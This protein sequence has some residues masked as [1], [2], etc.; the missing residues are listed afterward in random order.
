MKNNLQS[1]SNEKLR[2]LI[3][4]AGSYQV[5]SIK[6][7]KSYG[8]EVF[9]ADQCENALALSFSDGYKIIDI[10]DRNAILEY[11]AELNIDGIIPMNDFGTRSAFF[12]AQKL[13]LP[14]PS[15][16]T[17]ICGND[18]GLMRDVWKHE[19]L[20][21]PEYL[22]FESFEDLMSNIKKLTFPIVIKPTDCGGGG[23]GISVVRSLDE[24]GRAIG[25]ATKFV[26]NS[27]FIAEN[28]IDGIEISVDSIVYR[29]V[30]NPLLISDKI[31]ANSIYR[32]ATSIHY[33]SCLPNH[34]LDEIKNICSLATES[35]GI[36]NGVSH[37]ELI[38]NP[39][40]KDVKLLEIGT[41]GG[42]GHVFGTIMEEVTGISGPVEYAKIACGIAP[43]LLQTKNS[44]C[45]YRF[46]NPQKTGIIK[47][48]E[49][50]TL[51]KSEP[52]LKDYGFIAKVGDHYHGLKDS[53]CRI[54]YIV[55]R[56]SNRENAI[57]N[58]DILEEQIQ[59]EI[60]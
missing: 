57:Y 22:I 24:I 30:S 20:P 28:F 43:N 29:G 46:F 50:P 48:L 33:P 34:V 49:F 31:K 1:I 27:R 23:R 14:S 12:A 7:I 45:V 16:L 32:V 58:A 39:E 5:N 21:Q 6:A 37:I 40:L 41:R 59:I 19:K 53:L 15:L 36:V 51:F 2:V 17:G 55:V 44:G 9:L 60:D 47:K 4:G 11:A 3:L 13:G 52:N 18:K 42:G 26:K 35:L 54:G 25:H 56:G 38:Y 10:K 8:F